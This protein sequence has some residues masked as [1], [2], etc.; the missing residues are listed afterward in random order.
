MKPLSAEAPLGGAVR[1]G[2]PRRGNTNTEKNN[3]FDVFVEYRGNFLE[4]LLIYDPVLK[5]NLERGL[6]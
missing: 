5:E 1:T 3:E 2:I 4:M 6:H